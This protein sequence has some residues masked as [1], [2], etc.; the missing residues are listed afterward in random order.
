MGPGLSWEDPRHS[1]AK[2]PLVSRNGPDN[3]TPTWP[4]PADQEPGAYPLKRD[5]PPLVEP[6]APGWPGPSA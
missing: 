2:H 3:A 1:F 6:A 5:T 4:L